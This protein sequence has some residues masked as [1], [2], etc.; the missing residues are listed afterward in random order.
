MFPKPYDY[1]PKRFIDAKTGEFIK[2]EHVISFGGG[3]RKC[4]GEA[5]GRAE[6]FLFFATLMQKF[7]FSKARKDDV[8]NFIPNSGLSFTPKPFD[9]VIK[10]R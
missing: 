8:L 6:T 5:L 7:K 1:N 4:I 2:S 9:I 3:K 10:E